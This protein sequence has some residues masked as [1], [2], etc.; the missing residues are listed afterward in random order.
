MRNRRFVARHRGGELEKWQQHELMRWACSC[1][2]HLVPLAAAEHA[3]LLREALATGEQWA[4]GATAAGLCMKAARQLHAAAKQMDPVSCAV[5][6]AVAHAVATAHAGD[7]S[8]GVVLY[9][10]KATALADMNA[11]AERSWQ[12]RQL[13]DAIRDLVLTGLREKEF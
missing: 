1:G 12:I 11:E 3:K 5:T 7:H 4:E 6:R 13:T 8:L 9:G 10:A 2:R